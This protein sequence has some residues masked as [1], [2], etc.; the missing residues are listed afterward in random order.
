MRKLPR[1]AKPERF[2]PLH[3][4]GKN[5]PLGMSI[6]GKAYIAGAFEHPT[7]KAEGISLAQL[8]AEC[9]RGALADAGL[10]LGDVDAYFA[11]GDAP[12]FASAAMSEYL[13]L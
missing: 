3:T 11:S 7:R 2:K 5:W 6:K 1:C 9:A 8:H 12:G 4:T 13:G 10:E